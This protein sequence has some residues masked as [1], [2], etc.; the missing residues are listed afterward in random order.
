MKVLVYELLQTTPKVLKHWM[1]NQQMVKIT[2]SIL[3]I[4]IENF[5]QM[6]INSGICRM[7]MLFNKSR[8]KGHD[9]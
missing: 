7:R 3:L 1:L 6:F 9:G 8:R 5:F 2:H 4:T